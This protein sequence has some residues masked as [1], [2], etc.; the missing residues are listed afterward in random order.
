MKM[1][2][3]LPAPFKAKLDTLRAKSSTASERIRSLLKSKSSKAREK[4]R[5]R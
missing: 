2:I 3:R 4:G 1:A 5:G